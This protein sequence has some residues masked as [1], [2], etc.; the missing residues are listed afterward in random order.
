MPKD[1]KDKII[2]AGVIFLAFLVAN[3]FSNA[4][5]K[6]IFNKNEDEI[7]MSKPDNENL[8]D[9]KNKET[10]SNDLSTED[11]KVYISGEVKNSGV[12]DIKDGDRLDDLVKRAGGFTEKADINAI[13]LALRLEDQMK[14][15]IPNIDENQ[16]INADNTNLAMGEVT[17]TNPKSSGQKININLASK[18]ELMTLPNIGEKRAQAILDYRQENKFTKIEDIKN[19]SGIGDKYFEAM[20][21]LITV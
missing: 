9:M 11:K 3:V 7:V 17:S 20:K 2:F 21:D 1:R 6:D 13:N 15:Y 5:F 12:Y 4:G 10:S 8:D 19:V 16:N 18:E 14:I